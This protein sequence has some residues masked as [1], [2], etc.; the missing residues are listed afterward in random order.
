[1][2]SIKKVCRALAL[3]SVGAIVAGC[4]PHV[5]FA[6][7]K[8]DQARFQD[9]L[10]RVPVRGHDPMIF[11]LNNCIVYKAQTAHDDILGW[12]VV[13]AS[14]WG[15]SS[16]PK[17]AT[18]CTSEHVRY[19]GKYIVVDFCAQAIGAGGGC[20]GGGGTYRSRTGE[21]QGW[22]IQTDN[23]WIRLPKY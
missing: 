6:L 1:M 11:G 16:Y 22:Q 10:L 4:A 14:D 9:G 13:L 23:G 15:Q 18:V 3:L 20:A 19:N 17:W 21:A 2:L 5:A 7:S 8:E 12:S